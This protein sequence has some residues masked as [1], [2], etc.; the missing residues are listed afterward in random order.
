MFLFL[1]KAYDFRKSKKIFLSLIFEIMAVLITSIGH[2]LFDT[3]LSE[4][5]TSNINENLITI[6][7]VSILSNGIPLYLIFSK[8]IQTSSINE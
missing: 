4:I 5:G 1:S 3:L 2:G 7:V 6:I 8:K